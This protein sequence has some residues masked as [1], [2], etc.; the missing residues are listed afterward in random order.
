MLKF[1]RPRNNLKEPLIVWHHIG[2]IIEH[3]KL[4]NFDLHRN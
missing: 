2:K 1:F 4:N 3:Y